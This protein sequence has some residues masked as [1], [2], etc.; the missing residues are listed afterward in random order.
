MQCHAHDV[1]ADML[2]FKY[3]LYFQLYWYL[4]LNQVKF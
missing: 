2:T 3:R 4:I 1:N